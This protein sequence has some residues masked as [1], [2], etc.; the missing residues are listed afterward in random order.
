MSTFT[1]GEK[2]NKQI[3]KRKIKSYTDKANTVTVERTQTLGV[4]SWEPSL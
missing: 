1:V 2:K 3:V 4:V